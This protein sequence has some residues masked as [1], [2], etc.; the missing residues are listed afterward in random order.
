MGKFQKYQVAGH[1]FGIEFP[2]EY[3]MQAYL[4]PEL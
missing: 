2:D 1:I 4:Q 3:D